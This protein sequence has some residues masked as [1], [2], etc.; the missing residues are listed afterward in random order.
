MA[1]GGLGVTDAVRLGLLRGPE[2]MIAEADAILRLAP[3]VT[4]DRF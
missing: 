2:A 4:L 1:F 3:F